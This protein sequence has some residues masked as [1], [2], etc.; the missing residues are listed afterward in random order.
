MEKGFD[1]KSKLPENHYSD[2]VCCRDFLLI[3]IHHMD[4]SFIRYN[5]SHN[6][7]FRSILLQLDLS[8]WFVYGFD[9]ATPK[10]FKNT[11]QEP[12]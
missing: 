10:V 2:S 11:V 12:S 6:S 9:N 8:V 5:L 1:N 4:D 7:L 3:H